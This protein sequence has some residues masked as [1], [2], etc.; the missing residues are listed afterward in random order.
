MTNNQLH[1]S[2]PVAPVCALNQAEP[3]QL[4]CDDFSE[5]FFGVWEYDQFT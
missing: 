1:V 4:I 2:D 3:L 5:Y